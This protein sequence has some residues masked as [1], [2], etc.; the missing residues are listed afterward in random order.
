MT[1]NCSP[2]S[3]GLKKKNPD[4][5]VLSR[6]PRGPGGGG[7]GGLPTTFAAP[8]CAVNRSFGRGLR[9]SLSAEGRACGDKGR[10]GRNV[11]AP[12]STATWG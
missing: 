11:G 5:S 4:G 10:A 1:L 12:W 8:L 6:P 3:L 9:R 2:I 7:A